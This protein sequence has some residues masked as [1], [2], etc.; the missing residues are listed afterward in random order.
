MI[1][2]PINKFVLQFDKFLLLEN[3]KR[4]ICMIIDKFFEKSFI[5][6]INY[7]AW[8]FMWLREVIFEYEYG[9]MQCWLW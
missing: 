6:V 2:D 9:N 5:D 8:W 1:I 7:K 4:N 3:Y